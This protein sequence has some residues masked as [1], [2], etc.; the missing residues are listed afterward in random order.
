MQDNI[1][2]KKHYKNKY[3]TIDNIII[4][5]M[6]LSFQAKGLFLYLWSKPNDWS[7][8]VKQMQYD[9][10]DKRTKIYSAISE[11][12]EKG[13]LIRKNYYINGKVTGVNYHLSDT[14]EFDSINLH[15]EN[16]NS[17]NL[18][19]ENLN[20]YIYIQNKD[21]TK[22]K[23]INN[24]EETKAKQKFIKPTIEEIIQ[25]SQER[26]S[27]IDCKEFFDYYELS[28]WKDVKGNSVR[29]WKQKFITWG[30]RQRKQNTPK[31]NTTRP[32]IKKYDFN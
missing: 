5:D 15:Q 30:G 31:N 29:N 12:K 21:N 20:E 19:S 17:E 8:N 24:K 4:N 22:I 28:N 6:S 18:N 25:Y 10:V 3:T 11:L 13:Y 1:K 32:I 2:I 7:V 27:N 16:L 23:N 9:C 26:N 14:K